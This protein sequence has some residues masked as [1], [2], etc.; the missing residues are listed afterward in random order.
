[1]MSCGTT[2]RSVVTIT[3]NTK[4]LGGCE[5]IRLGLVLP[6]VPVV[7]YSGGSGVSEGVEDPLRVCQK[8]FVPLSRKW[9]VGA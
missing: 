7:P 5:A 4:A 9:Q 3:G 1:M 2:V 8:S 6:G